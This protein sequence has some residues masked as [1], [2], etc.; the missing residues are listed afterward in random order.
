[1][2]P[3]HAV[4]G[5]HVIRRGV[6]FIDL[7][8]A[9]VAAFGMALA[10]ARGVEPDSPAVYWTSVGSALLGAL[11]ISLT[12]FKLGRIPHEAMIGIVFVLGSAGSI[13]VLQYADHGQEMLSTMLD[14]QILF[15]SLTNELDQ[16]SAEFKRIATVFGI[17]AVVTAVLWKRLA[18]RSEKTDTVGGM[19]GTVLDFIFYALIGVMVASSVQ[20]AG[21][22]VVFTWLVMPAVVAW[23]WAKK[24]STALMIAIPL[25]CA[26]S[27]AG[28]YLSMNADKENMGG[29]PTGASIVVAFGAIVA[30]SYAVRLLWPTKQAA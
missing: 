12:R 6:I 11:L 30:V 29:W 21:V 10:M 27:F 26:G 15:V 9:Q 19:K 25:S 22:L 13:I 20:I 28:L 14:G 16:M 8:I 18:S 1:M 7:A 24:M 4:F 3:L 17:L 5:L 2:A 23:M